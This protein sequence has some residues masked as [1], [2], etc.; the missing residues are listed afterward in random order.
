MLDLGRIFPDI[1]APPQPWRWIEEIDLSNEIARPIFAPHLLQ[2]GGRLQVPCPAVTEVILGCWMAIS[3]ASV[4]GRQLICP[5][6]P[7]DGFKT[8]RLFRFN[9]AEAPG[10]AHKRLP[11]FANRLT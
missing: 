3:V 9:L 10:F 1:G 2:S 11:A 8:C 5:P 7:D 4:Q 6:H